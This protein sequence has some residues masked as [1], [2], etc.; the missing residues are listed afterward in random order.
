MFNYYYTRHEAS[1]SDLQR[2]KLET[3]LKK[4]VKKLQ[5]YR[6]QIKTW[7][8]NEALE[9][10]IVPARLQEHRR[11]VEEAMEQ[12]KD[13][14]K[15]SKMKSYLNQLIMLAALEQDENRN[16]GREGV[17]AVQ[18]LATCIEE[19]GEQNEQLEAEYDRLSQKKTT[20]KN[21][22]QYEER[23]QE[24]DAF[25]TRNNF[26]I[27]RLEHTIRF[28][29]RGRVPAEMVTMIQDDISFYIESNQEPDF[30]DDE[31]LYDE[32]FK[33]ATRHKEA[34]ELKRAEEQQ[35]SVLNGDDPELATAPRP[36][37]NGHHASAPAS[38][39]PSVPSSVPEAS[40]SSST[41][42]SSP[43]KPQRAATPAHASPVF[44]SPAIIKTLKPA[45]APSKPVGALKWAALAAGEPRE[46]QRRKDDVRPRRRPQNDAPASESPSDTPEPLPPLPP[47]LLLLLLLPV[48]LVS[49][50]APLTAPSLLP[51]APAA[52]TLTIL[53]TT[54][55]LASLVSGGSDV[56]RDLFA[57]TNLIRLP[58][59]IQD[60]IVSFT[61]SRKDPQGTPQFLR[62]DSAAYNQYQS[63]IQKPFLP[64]LL[65]SAF[66]PYLAPFV[67]RSPQALKPP[68]NLLKL[69]LYWNNLRLSTAN[70]ESYVQQI[71]TLSAS[72]TPESLAVVNELTMVLFYGYYYG[73][74]PLENTVA[75]LCLYKLGWKPY[76]TKEGLDGADEPR[77]F[78]HWFKPIA[79]HSAGADSVEFGDYQVFDLLPWEI[80]VKRNFRFDHALSVAKPAGI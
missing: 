59:G 57:D 74:V 70:F 9:A 69:Q 23:K 61:A 8:L 64:K 29:K 40:S 34:Q 48:L 6:D 21:L 53:D 5:K 39:Q 65:R 80:Y 78:Y 11:L 49:Q 54:Y 35:Q 71:Q 75:E 28:L 42:S 30:V 51:A 33:E 14:E 79:V 45:A 52:T 63:P 36:P 12:Y 10:S 16:L 38:S 58:P 3:D 56:E 72:A 24:I 67:R 77:S 2:D 76:K 7:Q 46:E 62:H 19:L 18:F 26:H 4:E 20:R 41:Q 73:F 47:V 25:T 22:L 15:L 50:P 17:A 31:T 32:I 68:P 13:V 44:S 55:P 1:Q 60:L 27:E 37:T 43:H 66:Y